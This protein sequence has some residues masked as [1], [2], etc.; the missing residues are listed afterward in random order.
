MKILFVLSGLGRGGA[1]EQVILLSKELARQGHRVG[2]YSLSQR[3]ESLHQLHGS[4]VEVAVDRKRRPVDPAVLWRLRKHVRSWRPDL[5]HAFGYD[6]D[7]YARLAGLGSGAPV[8]NS[9]RTDDQQVSR[10]QRLGYRLT[11]LL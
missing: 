3:T 4:G 8:L 6:A 1:E 5:V 9:E 10:V 2:I 7:V 11:S